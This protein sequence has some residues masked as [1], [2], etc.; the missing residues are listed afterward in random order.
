[1]VYKSDVVEIVKSGGLPAELEGVKNAVNA[2]FTFSSDG[3]TIS[4]GNFVI[5][6]VW[7]TVDEEGEVVDQEEVLLQFQDGTLSVG[8]FTIGE[9]KLSTN[10]LTLQSAQLDEEGK[11]I[12]DSQIF[13][14]NITIGN[15]AEI[16]DYLK[17]GN[18]YIQNPV[19]A[20]GSGSERPV[21]LIRQGEGGSNKQLF[22]LTQNAV[23]TL[24][25]VSKSITL[26]G[27][28]SKIYGNNWSI[29]SNLA[30]FSNVEV[31]GII[32]TASF[33]KNTI[34][35]VGSTMIFKEN[36]Q[37]L[38]SANFKKIENLKG[39][40]KFT[41]KTSNKVQNSQMDDIFKKDVIVS[42]SIDNSFL[43]SSTIGTTNF[44]AR[45]VKSVSTFATAEIVSSD[46]NLTLE[47]INA[48]LKNENTI[49]MPLGLEKSTI[50]SISSNSSNDQSYIAKNGLA[51]QSFTL[52]DGEIHTNN[53]LVLGELAN[54]EY[55]GKGLSGYGLYCE[56]VYLKGE[57]I[58]AQTAADGTTYY[59]GITSNNNIKTQAEESIIFWAGAK[60]ELPS[61]AS[62]I[63]FYVTTDGNLYASK[64]YFSGSIL[65]DATITASSLR[66]AEIYPLDDSNSASLKIY[67]M[68]GVDNQGISFMRLKGQQKEE[69]LRL[70]V[71]GFSFIYR[72]K[73][74]KICNNNFIVFNDEDKTVDF[75]GRYFKG[76][77]LTVGKF[78]LGQFKDDVGF[79]FEKETDEGSDYSSYL[80]MDTN[81]FILGANE[82]DVISFEG[83]QIKFQEKALFSGD[84][85]FSQMNYQRVVGNSSGEIKELGYDLF[86]Q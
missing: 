50:F 1:M 85:N 13:V 34:Q 67:N 14:K 47:Q 37:L 27:Q 68:D 40:F 81:G 65:T 76:D 86:I 78:I 69:V 72:D 18:F 25:E 54:I 59:A 16:Q 45:I 52:E 38:P 9:N 4:N 70:S 10:N 21:L 23:L 24:G 55:G 5:K 51:L 61:K 46:Q 60:D 77:R 56:N 83:Q 7:D 15:G 82:K 12:Q 79:F 32:N 84:V 74:K 71:S 39:S 62:D 73:N 43:N 66:A 75:S 33:S 26:N 48:M 42:F 2:G 58:G 6:N 31:S 20:S 29:T 64:G 63:P 8:G 49:V 44:Y 11:I 28:E 19:S 57:V 22:S 35:S 30:S 53:N 3:L 80:K 17:L 41:V 36:Y